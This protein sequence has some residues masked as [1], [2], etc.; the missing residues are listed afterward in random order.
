MLSEEL[1]GS[2]TSE[3]KEVVQLMQVGNFNI[4]NL[5]ANLLEYQKAVSIQSRLDLGDVD[6][7]KLVA[8]L[9]ADYQLLVQNKGVVLDVAVPRFKIVADAA[10]LKMI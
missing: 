6:V 1:I 8:Q 7:S 9:V 10:K 3:Q 4:M 5:V 2:L